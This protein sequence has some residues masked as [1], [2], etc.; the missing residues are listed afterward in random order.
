M[1][2]KNKFS[3]QNS[4]PSSKKEKKKLK[5][6]LKNSKIVQINNNNIKKFVSKKKYK[7]KVKIPITQLEFSVL[8][9][10]NDSLSPK[11][12]PNWIP[13]STLLIR[14]PYLKFHQELIDMQVT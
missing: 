6:Q 14:D 2:K 10:D 5:R 4:K 9:R 3:K 13:E 11:T 12:I 7:K 1:S 8:P